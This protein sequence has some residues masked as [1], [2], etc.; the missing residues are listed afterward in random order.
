MTEQASALKVG[1]EVDLSGLDRGLA[2]GEKRVRKMG[3]AI[4]KQGTAKTRAL[5]G[6]ANS[7][8]AGLRGLVSVAAIT[9]LVAYSKAAIDAA[10]ALDK[11]ARETGLTVE[12]VQTLTGGLKAS[13]IAI[14]AGAALAEFAKKAAEAKLQ[15]GELYEKLKLASPAFAEQFRN[16][17]D[18][19]DALNVFADGVARV[20]GEQ[21]RAAL[22]QAAFGQAGRELVP[23]LS[24]GAKGLEALNAKGAEFVTQIDKDAIDAAK[25]FK[26]E[27]GALSTEIQNKTMNSISGLTDALASGFKRAR[28]LIKNFGSEAKGITEL[29]LFGDVNDVDQVREKLEGARRELAEI[30][31]VVN[32]P[33][34]ERGFFSDL[35][36][37]LQGNTV[38]ELGRVRGEVE[39][40]EKH[41]TS[42]QAAAAGA[43]K[44]TTTAGASGGDIVIRGK[45][46]FRGMDAV[47]QSRAALASALGDTSR[48]L[49]LET[50]HA[51]T[52]AKRLLDERVLSENQFAEIRANINAAADAKVAENRRAAEEQML[53]LRAQALTAEKDTLGAIGVEYDLDVSRYK[54]MLRKKQISEEQFQA[55]R[56][57]LNRTYSV[58]IREEM[59][60]EAEEIR[61]KMSGVTGAIGS[62]IENQIGGSFD[63]AKARANAFLNDFV[64][65]LS[66][67]IVQLLIIKPL[68]ESLTGGEKGTSAGVLGGLFKA[69]G[70][71]GIGA[72]TGTATGAGGW[73]ATVSSAAAEG[74]DV[75]A[76]QMTLVN[77]RTGRK[78]E[79]F[80]PE[81]AGRVMPGER[82]SG[83][84]SRGNGGSTAT[85]YNIDARGADISVATRIER[86]LAQAEARR[87]DPVQAVAA[88]SRRHPAR[89]A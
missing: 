31:A 5:E 19:A 68:I 41:Y 51:I 42:L 54:E 35:K 3:E 24:Q 30:E 49:D 64:G 83:G 18:T 21:G 59:Q 89:A 53:G 8:G 25:R 16:A 22:A 9:G 84:A 88:H 82:M 45:V 10:A 58:R 81:T 69:L 39:A 4:E 50:Q 80:V 73:E 85:I 87:R 55:A 56:E 43:W 79:V 47:Q 76:G 40:L 14:D 74:G 71:A 70:V 78:P 63:S 72:A 17:T 46:D 2:E 12:T 57:D 20:R 38:D 28:D 60:R 67:A 33:A 34:N 1:F 36:A 6:A 48:Q 26:N 65:G 75:R 7:T 15:S 44:A 32:R 52:N 37:S 29:R 61:T 77:E 13:G 27:L 11:M 62:A 23:I 86:A 66:K